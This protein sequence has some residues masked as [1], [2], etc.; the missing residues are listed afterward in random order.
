MS[1]IKFDVKMQDAQKNG[2]LLIEIAHFHCK[3]NVFFVRK[4]DHPQMEAR[5]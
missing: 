5:P 3:Y 1:A 4:E 2:R